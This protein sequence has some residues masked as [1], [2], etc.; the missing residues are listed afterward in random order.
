MVTRGALRTSVGLF[1]SRLQV[2]SVNILMLRGSRSA[3]WYHFRNVWSQDCYTTDMEVSVCCEAM[4]RRLNAYW[5]W[6]AIEHLKHGDSIIYNR[7]SASAHSHRCL[8]S[9]STKD[10]S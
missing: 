4:L 2:V 8:D 5:H 1:G 10:N 6:C 9:Q 7:F 3:I